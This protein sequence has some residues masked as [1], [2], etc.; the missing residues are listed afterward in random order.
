L[1]NHRNIFIFIAIAIIVIVNA[2]INA[3]SSDML[4]AAFSFIL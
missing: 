4:F 1:H 2:I 3:I